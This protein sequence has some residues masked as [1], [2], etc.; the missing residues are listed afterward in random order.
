MFLDL[1]SRL[2]VVVGGDDTLGTATYLDCSK[3]HVQGDGVLFYAAERFNLVESGVVP[4]AKSYGTATKSQAN[5][6]T[7]TP[8]LYMPLLIAFELATNG[9]PSAESSPSSSSDWANG[10]VP[11]D[12]TDVGL[13][14]AAPSP[15]VPLF[16]G[17]L[18]DGLVVGASD[19][20]SDVELDVEPNV[21]SGMTISSSSSPPAPSLPWV[22]RVMSAGL[23]AERTGGKD[24]HCEAERTRTARQP[25]PGWRGRA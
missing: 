14:P 18:D 6:P 2:V 25:F 21:A 3:S 8:R 17:E 7:P 23:Q 19:V 15:L 20:A 1:T 16:P 13:L 12:V 4:K 9:L 22:G 10:A 5:L 11:S 24:T